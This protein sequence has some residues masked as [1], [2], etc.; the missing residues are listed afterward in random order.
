[1]IGWEKRE[2]QRAEYKGEREKDPLTGLIKKMDTRKKSTQRA[3]SAIAWSIT[4]IF[5]SIVIAVVVGL[6][7][8]RSLLRYTNWGPKLVATLNACQIKV[9]N[10]IY[11]MVAVKLNDWENHE[12]ESSYNNALIIKLFLFQFVNSYNSLIYIAFFKG[13]AEGCDEDDCM[14]ELTTQLSTIFITNFFLN[15]LELGMPWAKNKFQ[16]W[17]E[18]KAADKLKEED[19]AHRVRSGMTYTEEQAGMSAYTSTIEDYMELI[20]QYG[21]VIMFS[22]AFT[23]TPLFALILCVVEIRVDAFK[24]C[25][26]QRRPF[27]FG[28]ESIGQWN[29][30]IAFL[31]MMGVFFNAAILSWTANVFK[32]TEKVEFWFYF[33]VIDHILLGCKVFIAY[34][35]RDEPS[36]V[37]QAKQWQ[38]RVVDERLFMKNIDP[39]KMRKAR[40]L[41]LTGPT[42]TVQFEPGQIPDDNEVLE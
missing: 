18:K 10:T 30:I 14:A 29:S 6:F 22:S 39:G 8:W 3:I 42:S 19:T 24:L 26:L 25:N 34:I 2:F 23:L 12:T 4:W 41:E 35:I 28:R 36:I 38:K 40:G 15:F 31:S 11:K 9:M 21:Y 1:M 27:P 16:N 37:I 20:I 17:K 32:S 7:M 13:K 33:F 5:I